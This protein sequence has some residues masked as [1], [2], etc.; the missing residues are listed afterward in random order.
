MLRCGM[1]DST[2][3]HRL[4]PATCGQSP[5]YCESREADI[6]QR[7]SLA[8]TIGR[9]DRRCLLQSPGRGGSPQRLP[10]PPDR[11]LYGIAQ[12][13]QWNKCYQSAIADAVA[14]SEQPNAYRGAQQ[15]DRRKCARPAESTFAQQV[16]ANASTSPCLARW[17]ARPL[18]P[19]S[20]DSHASYA[21]TLH[22]RKI[23]V[24]S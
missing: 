21:H 1:L 8:S 23:K 16:A 14:Q 18:G 5:T 3:L 6:R 19:A 22:G 13:F 24:A 15:Q 17:D 4:R 10:S 2:A 7:T 12:P 20:L 11:V 9:G